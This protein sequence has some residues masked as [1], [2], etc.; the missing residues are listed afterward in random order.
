MSGD[1]ED[2]ARQAGEALEIDGDRVE[3]IIQSLPDPA[4]C[5]PAVVFVGGEA[6]AWRRVWQLERET[7][8]RYCPNVV[9]KDIQS[10]TRAHFRQIQK[11]VPR[12]K[13]PQIQRSENS[14][15]PSEGTQTNNKK[16]PFDQLQ[17]LLQ[18]AW[19]VL[20]KMGQ[21]ES[22]EYQTTVKSTRRWFQGQIYR[23]EA[24]D[25]RLVVEAR[26]RGV[27]LLVDE[28][29]ILYA[30]PTFADLQQFRLAAFQIHRNSDL[31]RGVSVRAYPLEHEAEN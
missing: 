1:A 26:G 2:L 9:K 30:K 6:D 4:N 31:A 23:L 15:S 16:L 27:I 25:K 28:A 22:Q 20:D 19:R 12:M 5:V 7:Y 8:D 10:R 11:Q 24:E 29:H 14:H 18:H 21:F 17:E 13:M 3:R